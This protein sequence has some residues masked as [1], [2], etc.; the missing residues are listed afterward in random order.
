MELEVTTVII[1]SL[2]RQTYG[3]VEKKKKKKKKSLSLSFSGRTTLTHKVD[4]SFRRR[5]QEPNRNGW[6]TAQD[7][8]NT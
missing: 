3:G 5:L 8:L 7:D 6:Q 2:R 4:K 1:I